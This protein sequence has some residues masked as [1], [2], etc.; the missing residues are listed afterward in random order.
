VF[1]GG[2]TFSGSGTVPGADF[3]PDGGVDTAGAWASEV[4]A[5]VSSSTLTGC[6]SYRAQDVSG[7]G[8][9]Q[10]RDRDRQ[11]YLLQEKTPFR[12]ARPA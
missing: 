2:G 10:K 4:A 8:M 12:A 6:F 1:A 5:G 9:P 11:K 7:G 3:S